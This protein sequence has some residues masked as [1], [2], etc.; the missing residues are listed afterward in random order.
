MS[1]H[2]NLG[3]QENGRFKL[4]IEGRGEPSPT[5]GSCQLDL[6]LSDFSEDAVA[7][8]VQF[9]Y[10]ERLSARSVGGLSISAG[11]FA[12]LAETLGGA[13]PR[14]GV[15]ESGSAPI[16]NSEL[17]L[18][19]RSTIQQE[20]RK[21]GRRKIQV[22]VL[23]SS[24]WSGRLFSIDRLVF[25]SN[26]GLFRW[27]KVPE[28]D[29]LAAVGLLLCREWQSTDIFVEKTGAQSRNSEL[30]SAAALRAG[31]RIEF[32]TPSQFKSELEAQ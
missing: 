30:L 27:A 10:G 19:T 24:A 18:T 20:Q 23:D 28:Q 32:L 2:V 31:Y 6:A 5:P 13:M 11:L 4:S 14:F 8:A 7:L 12:G 1:F 26:I 29:F 15:K 17:Y 25:A 21:D 9:L 16:R 3:N 22:Q